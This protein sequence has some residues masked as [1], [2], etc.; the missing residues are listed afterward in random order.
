MRARRASHSCRD[1]HTTREIA[2]VSAHGALLALLRAMTTRLQVSHSKA[3]VLA[4]AVF[5]PACYSKLTIPIEEVPGFANGGSARTSRGEYV[6][7]NEL[8]SLEPV[9]P[10]KHDVYVVASPGE[11]VAVPAEAGV[12]RFDVRVSDPKRVD[13]SPN[14]IQITSRDRIVRVDRNSISHLLARRQNQGKT[15]GVAIGATLG[16][17]AFVGLIVGTVALA[18][19]FKGTGG[20]SGMGSGWAE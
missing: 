20:M 1:V 3:F 14:F 5:F 15:A 18:S 19:S 12:Q 9:A 8:D 4:R 7:L 17:A 2:R 10:Q 11:L 16:A 6:K 13:V